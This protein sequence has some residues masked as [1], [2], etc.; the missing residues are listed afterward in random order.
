MQ[1]AGNIYIYTDT[2]IYKIKL[3]P[4]LIGI[5]AGF[6]LSLLMGTLLC[7]IK[8]ALKMKC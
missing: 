8:N 6:E 1:A 5:Q 7:K 2:Y 4:C 3:I